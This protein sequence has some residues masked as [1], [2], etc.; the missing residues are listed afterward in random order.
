MATLVTLQGPE[1][2][3]QFP[4][5]EGFTLIGRQLNANIYLDSLAVSRQ[6]AKILCSEHNYFI[7]DLN[8]SNGTY[9]N[10]QR[11]RGRIPLTERDTVQ[12]GPY[13]LALRPSPAPARPEPSPIIRSRVNASAANYTLFQQNSGY[14]LQ[15]VLD[16]AQH[17]GHTL[18]MEPLLGKLLEQLLL[19]FPQADRALV[20]LCEGDDLVLRAFRS[21]RNGSTETLFS[22]SLVQ[23]A[24]EEGAGILSE[25]VAGDERVEKTSTLIGLKLRSFLCVPLISL[26]GRRQ[27]VIQLDCT[28][29]GMAFKD[30]DL[31]VLTAIGL[32]VTVVLENASLHA[33]QLQEERLRQEVALAREIQQGFLPNDFTPLGGNGF[34]LFARV[35]PAREVSGDLYDFFPLNDGRLAFF[36]GDVSGK[37][38]PAALFMV[39]VRT[40]ARHLATH[41][42]SP[43]RTLTNLHDALAAD[44]PSLMFVTLIHGIYNPGDGEVV[45]ASGGHP[46][47]LL[48]RPGGEVEVVPVHNG[49]LLGYPGVAP[50]LSDT[51]FNLQP[52]ATLILYTD[53]F[54]EAQSPD[55]QTLFG[56][57]QLS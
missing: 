32:Q 34:E 30:E 19:L 54:T 47:P 1:S 13:V 7:E 20:V 55:G 50:A 27:G 57:E 51:R 42:D 17:L 25:D 52:G 3:R 24:L 28:L 40:L 12:I 22:R 4:L 14:K 21:R 26:E 45:L 37:G 56:V 35:H 6:H 23:R 9:V 16:I 2:G 38:M 18:E 44:N 29:P 31:E 33:A 53:G 36:I 46:P 48:R 10:G 43:A 5:G 41:G 39:A 15:V 8:S 11:I 49:R